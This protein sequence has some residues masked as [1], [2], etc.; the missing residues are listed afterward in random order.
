MQ[1][2]NLATL[3]L[4]VGSAV[5]IPTPHGHVLHEK[6]ARSSQWQK[7][8]RAAPGT[9]L[10]VRIGI[11]QPD[12]HLGHDL[13]MEISNPKSKKYGQYL[14]AEEVGDMFRPKKESL[15]T[16]SDWLHNSGIESSRHN[17]SAGRGWVKF[18]ASVDELESL[19]YT[20]YHVYQHSES[21]EEHLG[22]DEYHIPESVRGHIDFITPTVSMAVVETKE[23]KRK[24]AT[25]AKEKRSTTTNEKRATATGKSSGSL[26]VVVTP[27]NLNPHAL[28]EIACHVAVTPEC[29]RSKPPS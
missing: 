29:L 25:A 28:T 5:A 17:I 6:R 15:K 7:R 22:C 11:S 2:L 14:S 20:Q 1:I 3:A 8:S 16:V 13:L 4:L 27:A 23:M 19:L 24:R 26:P 9:T 12:I 10:P 21:K 18:E